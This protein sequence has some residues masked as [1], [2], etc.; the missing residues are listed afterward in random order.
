MPLKEAVS[1][2]AVLKRTGTVVGAAAAGVLARALKTYASSIS[3]EPPPDD[4]TKRQ[5]RPATPYGER[6][7]FDNAARTLYPT[8]AD[9][10]IWS[11]TPLQDS[12]GIITPSSLH[13]E[14]HHAGVP[15]IDP[16]RHRLLIHGIVKRPLIFTVDEVKRFPSVSR[17]HFIECSGNSFSE[18]AKPTA[19][20]VQESHGLTSCSEWTGTPLALLLRE[21]ELSPQASWVLAE[22]ADGAVMTRSLPLEKCLDDVIVAY[23]QNGEALRPEQGYSLRLVVPGWEGSINVKWLRRLK[24]VDKPYQTREET[25]KY[26]DLMP[27]GSA[28]QFTFVMESKSVITSPSGGQRLSGPGFFEITGLA[29][30]GRG[31]VKQVQVSTDGG[32]RWNEAE[33]QQPV[34][35]KCHTRF[36][37][38]WTWLGNATVLQSRCTDETGYVQ[39]TRSA[40]THV[41]GLQSYYH[42]NGIQSWIVAEDGT[43]SKA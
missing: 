35:P 37:Y 41:R 29:W 15:D 43:V 24:V 34:L 14:R 39:P 3:A 8:D 33:L 27:D 4:P 30:S 31:L 20:T 25:A 26:T 12:R 38:P 5:G 6:S 7:R 22:G 28:R 32:R 10:A 9:K 11:Y 13:Y 42:F 21:V 16:T 19:K 17:V 23:G 2:R 40:L 18:W 1:R 36:R